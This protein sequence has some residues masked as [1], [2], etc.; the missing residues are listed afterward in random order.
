M[1]D[2]KCFLEVHRNT[3][4][5]IALQEITHM[6]LRESI[7]KVKKYEFYPLPPVETPFIHWL[8]ID[9][10]SHPFNNRIITNAA[11][12]KL[13]EDYHHPLEEKKYFITADAPYFGGITHQPRNFHADIGLRVSKNG[14]CIIAIEIGYT[15]ETRLIICLATP[16]LQAIW[17]YPNTSNY[18]IWSKGEN[19][20]NLE[21]V[22]STAKPKNQV[23]KEEFYRQVS[24]YLG[25]IK[26]FQNCHVT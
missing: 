17:H 3:A 5:G 8:S 22:L 25:W 4:H 7:I 9:W 20:D 16:E 11:L 14:K 2:Y 24:Q 6:L 18:Y 12:S 10:A 15:S 13:V 21:K 19:F 1:N 26:C 23:T